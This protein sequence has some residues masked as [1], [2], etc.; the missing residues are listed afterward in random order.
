LITRKWRQK[1]K[2]KRKNWNKKLKK[3]RLFTQGMVNLN[4]PIKDVI[5]YLLMKKIKKTYA[6]IM[7]VNLVFTISRNFGLV[8]KLNLG[9]G[10]TL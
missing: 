1:K 4:V 6:I 10:M 2:Q 9:I 5:N 7:Q 8:V 3:F